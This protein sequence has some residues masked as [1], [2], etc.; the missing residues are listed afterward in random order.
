MTRTRLI[1]WVASAALSAGAGAL[2]AQY[3][4]AFAPSQFYW[5]Q[6]FAALSMIVIGGLATVSGAVTGAAIITVVYE[7]L[8]GVEEDGSFLGI[9]VPKVSGSPV[10][11]GLRCDGR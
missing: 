4:L 6:V 10:Q 9:G 1:V 11:S 3:N 8:P 5:T 7:I 2:W